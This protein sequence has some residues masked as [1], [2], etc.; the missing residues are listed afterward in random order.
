MNL[1]PNLVRQI[2]IPIGKQQY[3]HSNVKNTQLRKRASVAVI[4]RL[5]PK[6][7]DNS[8]R[9][10]CK[11]GAKGNGHKES[12][13]N[14]FI[15]DI[16]GK[17]KYLPLEILYLKRADNGEVCFPGGKIEIGETDQEAAERETLEEVAIDL[18]SPDFALLG[19]MDDKFTFDKIGVHSFVY[20]QL[21]K[22]S[23]RIKLSVDELV[24]YGWVNMEYILYSNPKIPLTNHQLE[25]LNPSSP[26]LNETKT[27]ENSVQYTS[28]SNI[29]TSR[30]LK[31]NMF[32]RF[33]C[34]NIYVPYL[35]LPIVSR[36][37][38]KLWGLTLD[39]TSDLLKK[40]IGYS[41]FPQQ[42]NINNSIIFFFYKYPKTF[43]ISTIVGLLILFKLLV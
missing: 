20:L 21:S 38:F 14:T 26:L 2:R 6:Y 19:R 13:L 7:N 8:I 3:I 15:E 5:E 36:Y 35:I 1:I 37:Q 29:S 32:L 25:Y 42:R 17:N 43:T 22:N 16:S 27:N 12:C 33:V 30:R 28:V 24:D 39:I 40:M 4:L 23:P 11:C 9:F 34:N 18:N 10:N 41:P 31:K